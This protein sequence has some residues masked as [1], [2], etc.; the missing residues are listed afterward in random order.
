MNKLIQDLKSYSLSGFNFSANEII[1]EIERLEN[2]ISLLEQSHKIANELSEFYG[3]A[4]NYEGDGN[5]YES[6]IIPKDEN[7]Q[8]GIGGEFAREKLAEL[9]EI[10]NRLKGATFNNCRKTHGV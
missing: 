5:Y 9:E 1:L 10:N 7:K 2:K 3:N 4:D 6:Y 8:S